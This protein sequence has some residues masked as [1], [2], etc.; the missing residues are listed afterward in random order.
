[1]ETS[2]DGSKA[3]IT[4][5]GV[6]L[7]EDPGFG[8]NTVSIVDIR[9]RR[10]LGTLDCGEH[11]RPHGIDLDNAG[12]IYVASELTNHLL[13][14]PGSAGAPNMLLPTRGEGSHF[15]RVDGLG[16][17]AYCS[18]M[19]SNSL[20]VLDLR[21]GA[22]PLVIT[23][24]ER[25]EGSVLSR[26]ESRLF[27]TNRESSSLSVIDTATCR[28]LPDIKTP[29]GPVRVCRDDGGRLLVAHYHGCGLAIIDPENPGRQDFVQLPGRAISVTFDPVTRLSALSILGDEVCLVNVDTLSLETRIATRSAPDPAVVLRA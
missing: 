22:D 20:S 28:R 8:G 16:T 9:A 24:G 6:A 3:F 13:R 19:F 21:Q 12:Q 7:A 1:M 26:D 17:W 5:F 15:V 10:R 27:V 4:Q 23:V 25:P 2:P 29:P 14:F 18:N 11:R